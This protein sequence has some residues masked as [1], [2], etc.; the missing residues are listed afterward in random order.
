MKLIA[1]F[2]LWV[3]IMMIIIAIGYKL[4]KIREN[5]SPDDYNK[6]TVSRRKKDARDEIIFEVILIALTVIYILSLIW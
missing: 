5:C 1:A 4:N 2:V 6:Q 3:I